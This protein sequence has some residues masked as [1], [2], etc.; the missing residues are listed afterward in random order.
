MSTCS[1]FSLLAN[2]RAASR[3]I[4]PGV[5]PGPRETSA[6]ALSLRLKF[7]PSSSCCHCQRAQQ[8]RVRALFRWKKQGTSPPDERTVSSVRARDTRRDTFSQECGGGVV[9]IRKSRRYTISRRARFSRAES[10]CLRAK[11]PIGDVTGQSA[12]RCLPLRVTFIVAG[13]RWKLSV[14][15]VG[16][17]GP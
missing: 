11:L 14:C 10:P 17:A 8:R 5:S 7:F 6:R 15:F 1:T 9:V 4:S 2:F 13:A 3:R 12:S 16:R